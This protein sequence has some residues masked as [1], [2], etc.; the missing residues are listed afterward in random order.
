[1]E[2][3]RS[4]VKG[5]ELLCGVGRSIINVPEFGPFWSSMSF[6]KAELDSVLALFFCHGE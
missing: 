1:M 6:L 5:T 2:I 4:L 3:R